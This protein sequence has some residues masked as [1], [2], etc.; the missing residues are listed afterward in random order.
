MSR[1][2]TTQP[3]NLTLTEELE[4]L[5]QSIT[6]TLQGKDFSPQIPRAILII[7]VQKLTTISA[8]PI[9][10]LLLASSQLSSSTQNIP[11]RSGKAPRLVHYHNARILNILAP[12]PAIHSSG[13][14]SS[15]PVPMFPYQATKRLLRMNLPLTKTHKRLKLMIAS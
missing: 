14:N 15:K 13:N 11:K 10:L 3:R 2:S 8:A 12:N 1:Q 7:F 6:L 5:E 9:V 4:K